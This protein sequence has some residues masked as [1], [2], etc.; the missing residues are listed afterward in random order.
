M[1]TPPSREVSAKIGSG[2]AALKS[3]L[4]QT[5]HADL[6]KREG[7]LSAFTP[8]HWFF[9]FTVSRLGRARHPLSRRSRS[10]P[11]FLKDPNRWNKTIRR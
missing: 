7:G 6:R 3:A 4:A 11:T 10:D 5:G 1:W 9:S 2:R 8:N